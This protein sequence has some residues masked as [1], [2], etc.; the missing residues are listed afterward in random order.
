[1]PSQL[2]PREQARRLVEHVPCRRAHVEPLL[3]RVVRSSAKPVRGKE[4]HTHVNDPLIASVTPPPYPAERFQNAARRRPGFCMAK[5]ELAIWAAAGLLCACERTWHLAVYVTIPPEVQE[6]Y[7]DSLPAAV[8]IAGRRLHEENGSAAAST[9]V[10]RSIGLVCEPRT[11]AISFHASLKGSGCGVE[12]RVQAWLESEAGLRDFLEM[13]LPV[14]GTDHVTA[15]RS[16][17]GPPPSRTVVCSELE[18]LQAANFHSSA[19][20]S[21][22]SSQAEGIAFSGAH[23]SD[24]DREFDSVSLV[25]DMPSDE[26]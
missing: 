15:V 1:M 14:A 16:P 11:T 17:P 26:M 2:I 23:A 3:R 13:R 5:Y 25:V 21:S 9:F 8:L 19:I 20:P 24:C 12:T 18:P 22:T 6:S 7:A 4:P 10:P